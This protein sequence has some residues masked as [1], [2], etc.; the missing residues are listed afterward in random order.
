MQPQAIID[1]DATTHEARRWE[2]KRLRPR[3]FS[4]TA[5]LASTGRRTIM[6]LTRNAA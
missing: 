2:P 4:A 6:H 1:T 5:K 3:P